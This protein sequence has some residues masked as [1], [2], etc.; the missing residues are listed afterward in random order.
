[1][2][3]DGEQH[4]AAADGPSPDDLDGAAVGA[5]ADGGMAGVQPGTGGLGPAD[6][7]GV[8]AG[9][10]QPTA[11]LDHQPAFEGRRTDL[12]AE[13]GG[14][15]EAGAGARHLGELVGEG[16][17]RLRA[18]GAVGDLEAARA[19]VVAL[20]AT[21]PGK[22]LDEVEGILDGLVHPTAQVAVAGGEGAR[23]GLE[24]G[25][26]HAAVAGAGADAQGAAVQH[27][28]R[29][30]PGRQLGRRRQAAVA[31]ADDDDVDLGWRRLG[32][33][34]E[35]HAARG[36]PEDGLLEVVRQRGR[37]GHPRRR[38]S[39]SASDGCWTM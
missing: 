21:R 24:L 38:S 32:D 20:D 5:H 16:P 31:A 13:L 27:R 3:V 36:V 39:Q 23:S 35:R 25:Q 33:D 17:E 28:H 18:P 34:V 26:H 8:E 14:W 12:V 6:E 37:A 9:R 1:M 10:V 30:A 11:A 15:D 22:L 29:A 19:H 7:A 2:G 4:V